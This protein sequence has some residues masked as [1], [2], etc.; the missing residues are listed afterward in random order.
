MATTSDIEKASEETALHLHTHRTEEGGSLSFE[1]WSQ[2]C[3]DCL[4]CNTGPL[5][6]KKKK[7]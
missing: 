7:K 5:N 1:D 6:V 4:K 2:E 3:T